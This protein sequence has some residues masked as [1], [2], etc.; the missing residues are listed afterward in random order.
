MVSG[1]LPPLTLA[2]G[3]PPG[4]AAGEAVVEVGVGAQLFKT[5]EPIAEALAVKRNF[6]RES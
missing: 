6:R 5:T 1:P 3:L 4:L 2:A